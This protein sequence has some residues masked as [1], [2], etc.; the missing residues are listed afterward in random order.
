MLDGSN[1]D[2][3]PHEQTRP[4][5]IEDLFDEEH[6]HYEDGLNLWL[7]KLDSSENFC[8]KY[9]NITISYLKYTLHKHKRSMVSNYPESTQNIISFFDQK[10]KHLFHPYNE[11]PIDPYS[12]YLRK[13]DQF[14]YV[15]QKSLE[16][17]VK[18][19]FPKL[20]KRRKEIPYSPDS[21]LTIL[22][23]IS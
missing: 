14:E 23:G 22:L 11:I 8:K 20:P 10:L 4:L 5:E 2:L 21:D 1:Y 3:Q 15:I 16:D 19:K 9:S 7:T 17:L 13:R 12:N 6:E 18:P